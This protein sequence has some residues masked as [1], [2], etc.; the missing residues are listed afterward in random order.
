MAEAVL[1]TLTGTDLTEAQLKGMIA[2][3]DQFILTN[4]IDG[5]SVL[6]YR[7]GDR[8]VDQSK[9]LDTARSLRAHYAGLLS[10][11]P[12]EETLL[13]DDPFLYP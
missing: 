7:I 6:T 13:A 10:E 11:I 12:A 9:A 8:Q 2:E 4:I 5:E 1:T 3:I